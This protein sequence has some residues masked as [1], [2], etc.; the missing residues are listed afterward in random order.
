MRSS[1]YHTETK[2]LVLECLK[3]QKERNLSV[4]DIM[5]YLKE[6]GSTA[7]ITTVYR[8]LD[9]FEEDNTVMRHGAED[10]K[11]ALFQYIEPQAG[12]MHHLHVQCTQCGRIIHLD[13]DTMEK[14][15]QHI[16]KE[17]GIE[18]TCSA[19]LLYGICSDCLKKRE[20]AVDKSEGKKL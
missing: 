8:I 3:E 18:I 20:K 5:A 12:C 2:D 7:N 11:K 17:H 1:I 9:K 6:H 19:S 15:I 14:A 16:S 13:C 10:G 4:L